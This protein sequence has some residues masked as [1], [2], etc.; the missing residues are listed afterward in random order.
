MTADE[1][2]KYHCFKRWR[3]LPC[4]GVKMSQTIP[5]SKLVLYYLVISITWNEFTKVIF[6]KV[7]GLGVSSRELPSSL[8]IDFNSA[9]YVLLCERADSSL[10]NNLKNTLDKINWGNKHWVTYMC[11]QE[12]TRESSQMIPVVITGRA[13]LPDAIE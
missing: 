1:T 11:L 13:F 2:V 8:P 7:L 12:D 3:L 5:T 4:N 6:I 10:D 9:A